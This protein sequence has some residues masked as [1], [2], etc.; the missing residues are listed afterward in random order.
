VSTVNFYSNLVYYIIHIQR[1]LYKMKLVVCSGLSL[2]NIY[3][4]VVECWTILA[5]DAVL[6][7]DIIEQFL[8]LLNSTTLYSE[9]TDRNKLRIAA[10]QPLAVSN[11][12]YGRSCYI[13][14]Q[15]WIDFKRMLR[16]L[17]MVYDTQNYHVSGLCP[18]CG[19]LNTR[20][21]NI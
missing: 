11:C 10:L 17:M 14:R 3:R 16:V 15:T 12:D 21:H 9:Q 4:S 8:Q 2:W 13:T 18:L 20:K 1:L 5:Q 6:S 7:E 19:I